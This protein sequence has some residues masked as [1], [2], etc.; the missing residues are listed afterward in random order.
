[1]K[2]SANNP[3]ASEPGSGSP[4][5]SRFDE[6][7]FSLTMEP[8][9]TYAAGKPASVAVRLTAKGPHHINQEYPHKMK[10]KASDGV[11]FPQP[12]IG[13]D[14]MKISNTQAEFSVVLTPNRSGKATVGG[15][16]AFSLCTADRCLI[17]KR[18]LALD[19]QVP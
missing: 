4:P 16:F 10:L 14:A 19:I 3:A 17:E 1:M 2:E 7:A 13:R 12:V 5:A 6:A 11:A 15:D 9:G 18:A 8:Q